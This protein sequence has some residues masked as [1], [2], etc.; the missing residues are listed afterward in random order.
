MGSTGCCSSNESLPY[1]SSDQEK[2]VIE[3]QALIHPIPAE[4]AD[5]SLPD[6]TGTSLD[7][8]LLQCSPAQAQPECPDSS[9][10]IQAQVSDAEEMTSPLEGGIESG[11]QAQA[12][13]NSRSSEPLPP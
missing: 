10:T 6:T 7:P 12:P 9:S 8:V 13:S 1:D 4:A 3:V 2:N 5:L 11:H